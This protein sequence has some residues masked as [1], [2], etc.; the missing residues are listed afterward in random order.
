MRSFKRISGLQTIAHLE[1]ATVG[2]LDDFLFELQ[3][4]A[5]F[6]WRIKTGAVFSKSG[7]IAVADMERIGR[8][9][10]IIRTETAIE[11]AGGGKPR[12]VEGRAWASAYVGMGVL[13]RGG[14]ALGEVRD[15]Y[16]E[17]AGTRV[18]GLLLEGNTA[19]VLDARTQLGP[20]A[21]ILESD[22]VPV[23]L[24]EDEGKDEWWT[25]LGG[26]MDRKA[27]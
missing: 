11:W 25:V 19:V 7:G 18:L 15:L 13:T 16:V 4:G 14:R 21:V 23:A 24:P 27:S 26:L 22:S 3:T 20:S 12:P 10:A 5:I 6:G 9:V 17:D 2:K 1:G 8:D